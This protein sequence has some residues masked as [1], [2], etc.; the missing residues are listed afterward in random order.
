MYSLDSFPT[1][2]RQSVLV[3]IGENQTMYTLRL[4]LL[5]VGSISLIM[6]LMY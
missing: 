3:D 6:T 5:P 2:C 1:V 4:K